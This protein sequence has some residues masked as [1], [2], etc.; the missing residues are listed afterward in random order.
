[1]EQ[2]RLIS[3]ERTALLIGQL[4]R[5]G[6]ASED[7]PITALDPGGV[8]A[9]TGHGSV[10]AGHVHGGAGEGEEHGE[11]RRNERQ[12]NRRIHR[13]ADSSEI[14]REGSFSPADIDSRE[15]ER[16]QRYTLGELGDRHGIL[17]HGR[18]LE[19]LGGHPCVEAEPI[20]YYISC[21]NQLRSCEF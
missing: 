18:A 12:Q 19:V 15:Q 10:A 6:R 17:A 9:R 14:E 21:E 1:M 5:R 3:I 8:A 11:C 20:L 7:D 4:E 2:R 13:Q 16:E